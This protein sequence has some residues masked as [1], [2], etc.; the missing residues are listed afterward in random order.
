M[1]GTIRADNDGE[2]AGRKLS[3]GLSEETI[4]KIKQV[5][6]GFPEIE[7]AILFGS[8]AK[9]CARPGSDIDL[10]LLGEG[11]DSS[12]LT[13][14]ENALDDALLPYTFSL[15]SH[16]LLRDA[17]FLAHVARVGIPFYEKGAEAA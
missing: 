13:R 6:A 2:G 14:I 10:T 7:R 5:F 8:R 11:I 15:S 9:G 12:L 3:H 4:S 17:D 16:K 1:P